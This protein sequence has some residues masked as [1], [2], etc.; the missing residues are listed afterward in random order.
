MPNALRSQKPSPRSS[1][2]SKTKYVCQEQSPK[3]RLTRTANALVRSA[4]QPARAPIPSVRYRFTEYARTQRAARLCALARELPPNERA[5]VL[6]RY[7]DGRRSG[8]IAAIAG[9]SRYLIERKLR[10]LTARLARPEYAFLAPRLSQLDPAQRAIARACFIEGRSIRA[11][12][13]HLNMSQHALRESRAVLLA[14]ARGIA[15]PPPLAMPPVERPP[16]SPA[17]AG[18]CI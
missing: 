15:T 16:P 13:I 5:L 4:P 10:R 12:A 14:L 17:H 9:C 11:A 8:E 6:A 7:A 2:L 1:I 3:L 18:K